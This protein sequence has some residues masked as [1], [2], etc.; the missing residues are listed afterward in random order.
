MTSKTA[1]TLTLGVAIAAL[2]AGLAS[3]QDYG[4]F[5]GY[6]LRVKLI[7]GAQY[8]PLYATIAEWEAATG[9]KVEILSRKNHFELDREIKQDIA[10]G[11]LDW[12]VGS[13]HTSFAPQYGD[14]YMDLNEIVPG[15][16]RAGFTPLL[17]EHSTVD[18]RLVQLPR[19]SD[20][21]NLFYQKSLYEDEANKTAFEAEYGYPLAPP[22]TWS[23][24][25]DQAKFFAN[26]PDF[27]GFQYVGKDEAVTGRFYELLVANGGAMFDENWN[28]TFNSPAGV[29][30]LSFFVDLYNAGAVPAGVPNY[31]WDDTGLGFGS[32]TVAMDLDWGGWSAYFN[33]PANSKVAGNVGVIRAPAGSAGIRTGWS[34]SHSFSITE[35][36]DNKEAAASF[37]MFLT[38]P[39]RQIVEARNGMLPTRTAVW[40][41]AMEEFNAAGNTYMAEVF[42][43]FRTSM[44]EDAFTPPLIPEWIEVSNVLWP[45]LQAAIVG[46]KTAQEALDT[47]AAAA[48]EIMTDA[49]YN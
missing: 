42:S 44:A 29:E 28:P 20:V 6:T 15:D 35:S 18:G 25:A 11:T 19:H 45:E 36:C 43:T 13:N 14:I 16:V 37:V 38:S 23:Q 27:Y 49:G 33:D 12:C 46:D 8:E 32:G 17:L 39:E 40:D 3:A 30:A 41:T 48:A 4:S 10:A 34:G 21:S 26:P 47:A 22:E 24:V 7:G 2:T 31:L 9:A 5:P 1:R